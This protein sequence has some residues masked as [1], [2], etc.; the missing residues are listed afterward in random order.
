MRPNGLFSSSVCPIMRNLSATSSTRCSSSCACDVVLFLRNRHRRRQ[1]RCGSPSPSRSPPSCAL[2][3]SSLPSSAVC[4]TVTF[5]HSSRFFSTATAA[6]H[7]RRVQ[8]RAAQLVLDVSFAIAYQSCRWETIARL[9]VVLLQLVQRLS[10][11]TTSAG[12]WSVGGI[13]DQVPLRSAFHRRQ[14]FLRLLVSCQQLLLLR[15]APVRHVQVLDELLVRQAGGLQLQVVDLLLA[16][17]L[18]RDIGHFRHRRLLL[19]RGAHSARCLLVAHC[20]FG[21]FFFW[22]IMQLDALLFASVGKTVT[23]KKERGGVAEGREQSDREASNV[24]CRHQRSPGAQHNA[25]HHRQRR[26]KIKGTKCPRHCTLHCPLFRTYSEATPPSSL[27]AAVDLVSYFFLQWRYYIKN[28]HGMGK[29][30]TALGGTGGHRLLCDLLH[31]LAAVLLALQCLGALQFLALRRNLPLL[32]LR[33]VGTVLDHLAAAGQVAVLHLLGG[34]HKLNAGLVQRVLGRAKHLQRLRHLVLQHLQ[35]LLHLRAELVQLL[36]GVRVLLRVRVKRL[37]GKLQLNVRRAD[38]AVNLLQALLLLVHQ[39]AQR[40]VQA[41]ERLQVL[42]MHL[43]PQVPQLLVRRVV[44]RLDCAAALR[45]QLLHHP[46]ASHRQVAVV[47]RQLQQL[48]VLPTYIQELLVLHLALLLAV[49]LLNAALHLLKSLR[50]QTLQDTLE[51]LDAAPRLVLPV[52]VLL[53]ELFRLLLLRRKALHRLRVL[54]VRLLDRVVQVLQVVL[55]ALLQPSLRVLDRGCLL[56]RLLLHI[57]DATKRL[58]LVLR[59]SNYAELVGHQLH[60]MLQQL[61]LDVVLFLRNRH[62]AVGNRHVADLLRLLDRRKLSLDL[63]LVAE[64]RR[65]HNGHVHALFEVLQHGHRHLR[66][67]RR[68]QL[69]AAQLVLDLLQLRDRIVN[70]AGEGDGARLVVVLLQLVQR[71]F[72]RN[73][74]HEVR[75]V[76]RLVQLAHRQLQ[77]AHAHQLLDVVRLR[78]V[79]LRSAFHRRQK[80]LRLLVSCQQLLLL[81]LAPVRHVQVLDELLV[82]QAGGLQ[83]Q[84]VDLLLA[85]SLQRDIGH[86]RHRRLLLVRGAHSARCLLVAHCLFGCFFFLGNNAV[87]C[88][89]LRFCRK[90]S[91]SEKRERRGGRGAGTV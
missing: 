59:L 58:V 56:K 54:H 43:Q 14:K 8:L 85:R 28:I 2:I 20:L 33:Q 34:M 57:L 71:L 23:V 62:L 46:D 55:A 45:H 1:S 76:L 9:V 87:G 84:V 40:L 25:L 13:L 74:L 64:Q 17:S 78:Q 38:V 10:A 89:S 44:A 19:V 36:L 16:R 22:G 50:P 70:R 32:L 39:L 63:L 7:L 21:C 80:F 51:L 61:R 42:L 83:L 82:R 81:R 29:T 41:A 88:A 27:A 47:H 65:L 3:C 77:P 48:L 5:M 11:L 37:D 91:H 67:L 75:L 72:Q 26:K 68:V 24:F 52:E 12:W 53:D 86:F 66:H 79:P 18:Q 60:E 49:V 69:R 30:A 4:T 90:D 35:L 73:H 15:L 31:R 6:R